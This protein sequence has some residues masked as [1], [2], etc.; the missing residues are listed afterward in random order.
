MILFN[1]L[2]NVLCQSLWCR[3]SN[4][5]IAKEYGSYI[6]KEGQI[7]RL[8]LKGVKISREG[9]KKIFFARTGATASPPTSAIV[10]I[11]SKTRLII[12]RNEKY[13]QVNCSLTMFELRFEAIENGTKGIAARCARVLDH[14]GI[15]RSLNR[16]KMKIFC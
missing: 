3:L 15:Y 10:Y 2:V 9:L 16:L 8:I 5:K 1:T 12:H 13:E 11:R 6:Y 4:H 14:I 7:K